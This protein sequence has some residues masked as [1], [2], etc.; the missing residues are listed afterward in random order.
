MRLP[1]SKPLPV[2]K[3]PEVTRSSSDLLAD[4]L[5]L[6]ISANTKRN[7]SKA[8][9]DFCRRTYD[10]EVSEEFLTQF[11]SLHQSE[12]VYQVLQYRQLL[13]EAK[14]QRFKGWWGTV[15]FTSPIQNWT[16]LPPRKGSGIQS[17]PHVPANRCSS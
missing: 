7:Y 4:F 14:L 16:G 8:I 1:V 15:I 13:I 5:R 12:A 2:P 10:R 11:L 6:K 17:V 3:S 9:A